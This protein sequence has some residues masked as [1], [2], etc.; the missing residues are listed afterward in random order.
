MDTAPIPTPAVDLAS[1]S[2]LIDSVDVNLE[3]VVGQVTMS[4]AELNALQPGAIIALAT[5]ISD[6]VDVRLNGIV[7]ARGELVSVGDQ[8]AVR[9]TEV[10]P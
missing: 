5:A 6:L 10:S 8:F 1:R 2:A 9:L 7:I 4:V 3:T